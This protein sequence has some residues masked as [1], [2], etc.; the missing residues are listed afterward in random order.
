MKTQRSAAGVR[1]ASAWLSFVPVTTDTR[2]RRHS[3]DRPSPSVSLGIPSGLA[4]ARR[5]RGSRFDPFRT[6]RAKKPCTFDIPLWLKY[7][8]SE[9]RRL[10]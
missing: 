8:F 1:H 10:G 6:T 2:L 9:Y 5:N 4:R 7:P 3:H